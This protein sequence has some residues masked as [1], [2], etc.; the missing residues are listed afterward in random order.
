MAKKEHVLQHSS[1]LNALTTN[2]FRRTP[3]LGVLRL[4][5][6]MADL[7]ER[8][9]WEAELNG[10]YYACGCDTAA[11]GLLLGLV[12]GVGAFVFLFMS[13]QSH[14]VSAALV[15]AAIALAG[16][17]I[18]KGIGLVRAQRRLSTT[19]REVQAAASPR[20]PHLKEMIGCG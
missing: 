18:G 10:H 3:G 15:G 7:P 12:A 17:I 4:G 14:V 11:K 1:E 13:D 8:E 19:A 9:R 2:P 16:A 6:V 20:E 5:G